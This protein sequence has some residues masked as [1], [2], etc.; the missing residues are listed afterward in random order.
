MPRCARG[1]K[2]AELTRSEARH[3]ITIDLH[4]RCFFAMPRRAPSAM[5]HYAQ[6]P[7]RDA[8]RYARDAKRRRHRCHHAREARG[9]GCCC[10]MP[11]RRW[12]RH[13]PRGDRAAERC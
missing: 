4:P 1:K 9:G 5:Q 2:A 7:A 8:R 3:I 6:T 11:R 12:R 10:A 13:A